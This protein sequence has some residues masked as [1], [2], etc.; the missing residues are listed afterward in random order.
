MFAPGS[1]MASELIPVTP[2][3]LE[4]AM[5]DSAKDA[6]IGLLERHRNSDSIESEGAGSNAKPLEPVL[7]ES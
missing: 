4:E 3:A 6:T 1:A 2:D 5:Y 7:G